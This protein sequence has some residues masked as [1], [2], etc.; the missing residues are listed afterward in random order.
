MTN[1]NTTKETD[2]EFHLLGKIMPYL[3]ALL[4][5]LG[6]TFLRF[7]REAKKAGSLFYKELIRHGLDETTASDLTKQYLDGSNL[8]HYL[9]FFQQ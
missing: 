6:G 1:A 7:K 5:R 8:K 2:N 3:P 4:F 9:R